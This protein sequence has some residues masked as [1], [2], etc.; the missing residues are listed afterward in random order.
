M[1]KNQEGPGGRWAPRKAHWTEILCRG[2]RGKSVPDVVTSTCKGPEVGCVQP[3]WPAGRPA[4]QECG[5]GAEAEV[6]TGDIGRTLGGDERM[7]PLLPPTPNKSWHLAWLWHSLP[8]VGRTH[9]RTG[10]TL[11]HLC[12]LPSPQAPLPQHLFTCSSLQPEPITSMSSPPASVRPPRIAFDTSL[13]S[14]PAAGGCLHPTV[15]PGEEG[16]R[17]C[18][19][20]GT[21]CG[22]GWFSG[23]GGDRQVPLGGEPHRPSLHCTPARRFLQPPARAVTSLP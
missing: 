16:A 17:C 20:V 6:G 2:K 13:R 8:R 10:R 5:L 11:W 3:G 12:F 7:E 14:P 22:D 21:G 19:L 1:E 4:K 9:G 15:L 23:T 18:S